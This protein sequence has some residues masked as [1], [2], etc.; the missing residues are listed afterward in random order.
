VTSSKRRPAVATP[1][2]ISGS[3]WPRYATRRWARLALWVA[4]LIVVGV[5][6]IGV[7]WVDDAAGAVPTGYWVDVDESGTTTSAAL[8]GSGYLAATGTGN[9]NYGWAQEC[10][11]TANGGPFSSGHYPPQ[12]C[13]ELGRPYS[14]VGSPE[15]PSGFWFTGN[16]HCVSAGRP[17]SGSVF[18]WHV[19]LP[20]SG[21]WHAE[22][23]I[24]S[25]TM[26]GQGN[27][28]IVN[29][30][31]GR[32][33]SVVSQ[34][35]S[36][37]QWVTLAGGTHNFTAGQDY[38][39]ELTQ[40]DTENGFCKYQ[41]AD[42]MKWVYDGSPVTPAPVNTTPPAISGEA[43]QGK[44][45]TETH[46]RWTNNPTSYSY[47]WE[48]CDI[49]GA[50]CL[51]IS[52]ANSQ[53]YTLAASD[54]GSTIAVQET[55][56]NGGGSSAPASSVATPVVTSGAGG[57]VPMNLTPPSIR[58]TAQEG[59]TL[60]VIPGAWTESPTRFMYQW[61]LCVPA[62]ACTPISGATAS[63]YTLTA[64]DVA[65]KMEVEEIAVNSA[66]AGTPAT[67]FETLLVS[68]PTPPP[69]TP[70]PVISAHMA[71]RTGTMSAM[72]VRGSAALVVQEGTRQSAHRALASRRR[73]H[74]RVLGLRQAI[75]R[76]AAY[77]RHFSV[78]IMLT[79][80]VDM[81][82]GIR[83]P[84]V[85][86]GFGV[87]NFK[88]RAAS[89]TV[90]LPSSLGGTVKLISLRGVTYVDAPLLARGR[91]PWVALRTAR[92]YSSF[93]RIPL[94]RDVAVMTNP[95]GSLDLLASAPHPKRSRVATA[96]MHTNRSVALVASDSSP[97]VSA[98][99][100]GAHA[101][102]NNAS[103]D[104]QHLTDT[105]SYGIKPDELTLGSW[106]KNTVSA[107]DGNNGVCEVS[108]SLENAD[109][110]GFDV[111][112]EFKNPTAPVHVQAPGLDITETW[113]LTY[114]FKERCYVGTWTSE[115]HTVLHGAGSGDVTISDQTGGGAVTLKLG[116]ESASLTSDET[117]AGEVSA[118]LP[119]FGLDP[120]GDLVV[121]PEEQTFDST[122]QRQIDAT[123]PVDALGSGTLL[124]SVA[125][126]ATK[127]PE[128]P[129]LGPFPPSYNQVS[130]TLTGTWDCPAE[131]T[132][133]NAA[134]GGAITFKKV[135]GAP[136][137]P[138]LAG[139]EWENEIETQTT[140]SS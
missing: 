47:Q 94:L 103:D 3:F 130:Y 76:T 6:S 104:A 61:E 93:N 48:N 99:C 74:S 34:E 66:G 45:L 81:F 58:G 53:S 13:A 78:A 16:E 135:S 82:L 32:S 56:T 117:L 77:S 110:D 70:C 59:Q 132:L 69:P 27:H 42:Q 12:T 127:L 18:T 108:V 83:C 129:P 23:Y 17:F 64:S 118:L 14:S 43:V 122:V 87:V 19:Q 22:A 111:V 100:P 125:G 105:F 44:T 131:L 54:V 30:A 115:D 50:N 123:G 46:G 4:A 62:G 7:G 134:L 38:T 89:W 116:A 40:S 37:G 79:K 101:V 95:L 92:D 107:E 15:L 67:S 71:T 75:A 9:V 98:S 25:W 5:C 102:A 97:S 35:A 26:Y 55:A 49:T 28:Y 85:L 1:A 126:T 29:S 63:T 140:G 20:Q 10:T 31:E 68:L 121:F 11:Q 120:S 73:D 133:E 57:S 112:I 109:A 96:R 139:T 80:G 128:A 84:Q 138:I 41:M 137:P 91:K 2:S 119:E 88:Q 51:P 90:A 52:G 39:V 86:E 24:P 8:G 114:H 106:F 60:S 21:P 36:H 124:V 33:E 113:K 65:H 72:S 136:A